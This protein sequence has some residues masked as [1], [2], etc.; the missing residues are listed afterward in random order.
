MW[1]RSDSLL[2]RTKK[3]FCKSCC[4]SCYWRHVRQ[5]IQFM[6]SNSI[7]C[8]QKSTKNSQKCGN[9]LA[10]GWQKIQGWKQRK[11]ELISK[12]LGRKWREEML[13]LRSWQLLN[14]MQYKS[15]CWKKFV[16]WKCIYLHLHSTDDD[17]DE[18][19][20]YVLTYFQQTN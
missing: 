11:A 4:S 17:H 2:G 20:M 1:P 7:Y 18:V 8:I 15:C 10:S 19:A 13:R 5:I 16:I 6:Y 3:S 12:N 14:V 9:K